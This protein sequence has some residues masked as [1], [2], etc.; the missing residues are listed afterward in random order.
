MDADFWEDRWKNEETGWD[1]GTV[2]PPL[3]AYFDQLEDK[4]LKILIP[5]CG[6]AYEAQ[7]L[8]EN[9]FGD[10]SV[11]DISESALK[12]FV[13]RFNSFP[14]ANMYHQDFFELEGDF[15]LIVEQTFFCAIHP[16][17]RKKYAKK[18]AELI[19]SG[20]HLMGLLFD[21]PLEDGP[22]FGGS[23]EE[24]LGYFSE[25]FEIK[26]LEA[27]RNSIPPRQGREFFIEF[28]RK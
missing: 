5:G 24:Y 23:K 22:P 20:G 12:S 27:C 28:E 6:N 1:M 19:K 25:D 15:D 21:F 2:S 16:D 13:K 9:G 26:H 4:S 7:Y 8:W 3:K 14:I 10:T 11:V 18:M 17:M